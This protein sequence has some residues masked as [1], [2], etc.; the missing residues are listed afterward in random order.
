MELGIVVMD[1]REVCGAVETVGL[2][3]R[4][5]VTCRGQSGE[6]CVPGAS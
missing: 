3:C 2:G 4:D 5:I 6:V 1:A